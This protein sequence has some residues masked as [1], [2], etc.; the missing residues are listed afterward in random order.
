MG[1]DRAARALRALP[2]EVELASS[3]ASDLDLLR[4]PAAD[5][6]PA[7]SWGPASLHVPAEVAVL[8]PVFSRPARRFEYAK[9]LEREGRL[10][11]ALVWYEGL[12]MFSVHD[13]P[14]GVPALAD[15]ARIHEALGDSATAARLRRRFQELWRGAEPQ[16][17]EPSLY[18]FR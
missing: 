2:V 17:R 15:R 5:R 11:E 12:G 1:L 8:S 10:A 7:T 4:D 14:W 9:A 13:L 16:R 3:L 6:A 18:P